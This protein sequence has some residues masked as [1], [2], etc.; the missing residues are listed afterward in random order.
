MI[1]CCL[2]I[3]LLFSPCQEIN[4]QNVQRIDVHQI[5]RLVFTT[6]PNPSVAQT[7]QWNISTF[8]SPLNPFM[9]RVKVSEYN[10]IGQD[11][12]ENL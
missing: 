9:A 1:Y 2:K 10:I 5:I 8:Y 7:K 12:L 6:T 4:S 3:I 11:S